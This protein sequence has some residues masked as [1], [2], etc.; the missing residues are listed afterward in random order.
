MVT[1]SLATAA[2][3]TDE[4]VAVL[5]V[6][7]IGAAGVIVG[8]ALTPL[9]EWFTRKDKLK[10]YKREIFRNFLDHAYWCRSTDLTEKDRKE[11][12]ELYVADFHRIRLIAG[13]GVQAV[14]TDD[15]RQPGSLTVE[16]EKALIDAF[17]AELGIGGLN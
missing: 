17:K 3:S 10:T 1:S 15:L 2:A 6:A 12:A 5:L 14:V 8:A 11:R 16:R 4:G 13:P 9:S 7:G